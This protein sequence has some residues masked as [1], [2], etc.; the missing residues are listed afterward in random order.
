V[1]QVCIAFDALL[2]DALITLIYIYLWSLIAQPSKN[3]A[4]KKQK[5]IVGNKK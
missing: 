3:I 5:R 2:T 1:L 4:K